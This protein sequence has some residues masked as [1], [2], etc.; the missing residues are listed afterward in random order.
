[1][2]GIYGSRGSGSSKI[3]L[4]SYRATA[5]VALPQKVYND[6][7]PL[8][9]NCP[10]PRHGLACWSKDNDKCLRADMQELE[11]KWKEEWQRKSNTRKSA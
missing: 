9:I 6:R 1:M 10:Y 7:S 5:Y 8:C 11:A 2:I 3:A 4:P